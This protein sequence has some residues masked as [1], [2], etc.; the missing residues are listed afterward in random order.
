MQMKEICKTTNL[1]SRTIRYYIEEDL[2]HPQIK[3]DYNGRKSITFSQKDIDEINEIMLLKCAL[4]SLSEIKELMKDKTKTAFFAEKSKQILS[5]RIQDNAALLSSIGNITT[6]IT[7]D[8]YI[9]RLKTSGVQ[10]QTEPQT[11][12][13]PRLLFSIFCIPVFI[14]VC[15]LHF[16]MYIMASYDETSV[17]I[18]SMLITFAI[19]LYIGF[20][21]ILL[22]KPKLG[23]IFLIYSMLS[24]FIFFFPGYISETTKIVMFILISAIIFCAILY[25]INLFINYYTKRKAL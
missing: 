12:L 5:A 15:Y 17:F 7:Y 22:A 24:N 13:F 14:F 3:I 16:M 20:F 2:I 1:S 6:D 11:V 18:N 25:F 8:D 10:P 23:Y 9:K 19:F 21:I 4:L